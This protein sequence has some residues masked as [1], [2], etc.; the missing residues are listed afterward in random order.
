MTARKMMLVWDWPVRIFHWSLVVSV[1]LAWFT[2][3]VPNMLDLHVIVGLLVLGLVVFRVCWGVLG[4]NTARFAQFVRGKQAILSYL[5]GE[6]RGIGHNPLGGWSVLA[7]L[8][9]T[10]LTVVSGLFVH[11]D[12]DFS[13]PL[14]FLVSNSVSVLMTFL[15]EPLFNLLLLVIVLHVT[16]IAFYRVV[17]NQNLLEPMFSGEVQIDE[18]IPDDALFVPGRWWALLLSLG[19]AIGSVYLASGVWQ[20]PPAPPPAA[21]SS[22]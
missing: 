15:H 12:D 5:Q 22:R 4:S 2:S 10:A 3:A 17:L 7:L 8:L 19:V 18:T 13:G 21:S 1:F 11:N 16:A 9:L 6:W 20:Q 14:A